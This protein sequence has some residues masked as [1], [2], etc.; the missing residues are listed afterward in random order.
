MNRRIVMFACLALLASSAVSAALKPGA[1]APPFETRA[2]LAGKPFAF[3]LPAALRKGPVVLYFFPAAFTPG[4]TVEAHE[5]AEAARQFRK[6][7]A[8]ILGVAG[9]DYEKLA[10]FSVEECRNKFPVGVATP[11]MIRDYDVALP[12]GT[13]SNRTSFVIAPNRQIIHVWSNSDYR[14]HV[15]GALAAIRTWRKANTPR[16]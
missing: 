3:S 8:S 2:A 9:D 12:L 5:F 14:G 1:L 7:G 4:C 13:R 6:L 11:Q 15:A 16:R 10:R